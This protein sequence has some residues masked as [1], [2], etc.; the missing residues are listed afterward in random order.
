MGSMGG[1]LG[2]GLWLDVTGCAHLFGGEA[3]LLERLIGWL[4]RQNISAR[5]GLAD[6]PG[7]AWALAR[8]ATNDSAPFTIAE[9]GALR[10]YLAGLP[11]AALRLEGA[12]NRGSR[13]V[14]IAA[15]RRSSGDA[16]GT[17]GQA[18]RRG[19]AQALGSGVGTSG[20]AYLSPPPAA[21]TCGSPGLCR[22]H[23]PGGGYRGRARPPARS[24]LS[25]SGS[26][27]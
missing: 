8:H 10:Q 23:R 3:A 19:R 22:A 9:S 7:A 2:A 4:G 24:A 18:V 6:T 15:H 1:S 26:R 11:V 14:G 27:R 20:R 21:A 16:P 5:A 12:V 13:P 25:G 17:A